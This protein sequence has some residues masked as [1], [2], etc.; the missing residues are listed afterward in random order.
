MTFHASSC[1]DADPN[2]QKTSTKH[3]HRQAVSSHT[4]ATA[5]S[6][7]VCLGQHREYSCDNNY[8]PVAKSLGKY[9]VM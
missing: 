4:N 1:V 3:H 9:M 5:T 7:P 2:T 6:T 8:L